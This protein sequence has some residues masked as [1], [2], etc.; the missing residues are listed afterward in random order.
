M[1]FPRLNFPLQLESSPALN[2]S[3]RSAFTC[4]HCQNDLTFSWFKKVI[5]GVFLRSLRV[6]KWL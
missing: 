5:K 6:N 3:K 1:N 4:F 2:M